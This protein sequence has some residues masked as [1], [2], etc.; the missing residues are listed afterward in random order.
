MSHAHIYCGPRHPGSGRA[1]RGHGRQPRGWPRHAA[2]PHGPS[3]RASLGRSGPGRNPRLQRRNPFGRKTGLPDRPRAA[4]FGRRRRPA[5]AFCPARRGSE[6]GAH[7]ERGFA[8]YLTPEDVRSLA[9]DL[10]AVASFTHWVCD[11]TSPGVKR[12]LEKRV[13]GELNRA[14]APF[15]F[16]PKEGPGFFATCGRKPVAVRSLLKTAAQ[17]N[18]LTFLFR[19]VALLP[20]SSGRQGSRPWS[21]VCLMEKV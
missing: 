4:G 9:R 18:R 2:L 8:H 19:L 16:A 12:M 5:R 20:E 10:A 15:K 3:R 17:L 13:G 6:E 21:G 7:T 1:G 14:G 11:I